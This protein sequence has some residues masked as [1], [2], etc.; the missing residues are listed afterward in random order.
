M[1]SN[2]ECELLEKLDQDNDWLNE[3]HEYLQKYKGKIIAI[4]NKKIIALSETVDELLSML[5]K[6]DENPAFV[7]IETIPSKDVAFIL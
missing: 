1:T 4:K 5:E 3:N 2:D 7:L 6:M